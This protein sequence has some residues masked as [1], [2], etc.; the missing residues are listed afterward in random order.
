[1]DVADN[2][3]L[4]D[5]VLAELRLSLSGATFQTWFNGKTG[6]LSRQKGTVEIGCANSYSK[7]WLEQRYMTEVK[8]ILDRLTGVPNTLVF[9]VSSQTT[10]PPKT[11]ASKS[12][13]VTVPLIEEE[14]AAPLKSNLLAAGLN[15]KYSLSNFIVGDS[16]QLSFAAARAVVDSPL[17]YYNP[18]LI[19]GGVGVGKT[20]LLQAVGQATILRRGGAKVLYTS[21]ET[22]TNDMVEAIQK[23]QTFDFREK[24]RNLDMLIIDDVQFI[25]GRES[26]Q[27]QFFHTFNH[28][29]VRGK[30]VVLS[31]DRNPK[32][33]YDLQ[34]RLRS[35][36]SGGMVAAVEPPDQELRE[37]ILLAKAKQGGITIDRPVIRLL[38]QML[39]P[40]VRDVEGGLTRVVA[41]SKLT[42]KKIDEAAVRRAIGPTGRDPVKPPAVLDVVAN[43]FSLNQKALCG[44]RR[45]NGTTFPR[46][47]A[48][49]LLRRGLKLPL[50]K[51]GEYFGD[52]DHTTVVYAINRVENLLKSDAEVHRV[53][54]ELEAR[55]FGR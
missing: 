50:K 17:D 40:S 3:F 19:Y 4:W 8:K 28:L 37:A 47:V 34:D 14:A 2:K 25:A 44:G 1:M 18:L 13:P 42:G 20:H 35:R 39:G 29:V 30:Q 54:A 26:T 16:N 43:Y 31:C 11:R 48:M 55:I 24:Y 41:V 10:T 9:R 5:S 36:F 53:V 15:Q 32:E 38:A 7:A 23:R 12:Q 45:D 22:F 21:S 49:P 52:K 46:Q 33:L 27:E 6:I 51:I